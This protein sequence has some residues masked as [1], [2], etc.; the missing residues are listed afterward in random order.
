MSE[1]ERALEEEVARLQADLL[2]AR[3]RERELHE[4]FEAEVQVRTSELGDAKEAAE[5]ASRAKSRFLANMSHELRTPL[6]VIIGY[7]EMLMEDVADSGEAGMGEDL[8]K[9]Q[10][11]GKHLLGLIDD[12]LDLSKIEA[13]KMDLHWEEV[14]IDALVGELS[15]TALALASRNRNRFR[16]AGKG[17][18]HTWAD[19]TKLRQVLFNL[20]ANACK[21]TSD[22]EV[23]IAAARRRIDDREEL[24]FAV[25]DTGVGMDEE[26][27]AK[28]FR[29]FMQADASSTRKYGGTGLGLAISKRFVEM[30]GG[31][32]HVR[33]RTGEGS[34]FTVRLPVRLRAPSRP[35]LLIERALEEGRGRRVLFVGGN[36][37]RRERLRRALLELGCRVGAAA[38]STEALGRIRRSAPDLVVVLDLPNGSDR[39]SFVEA[40]SVIPTPSRL[41]VFVDGAVAGPVPGGVVCLAGGDDALLSAVRRWL[42]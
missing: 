27:V 15:D 34:T 21:F 20:L 26:T 40:L 23:Q 33:S 3:E 6:N 5:A 28:L 24:V 2:A 41:D 39:T 32:I 16:V 11:A 25:A 9:I 22:G 7:A 38:T 19:A 1:R 13:G 35:G 30:M 18:G 4:S 29:P 10:R 12:I 37:V 8:E 17:L 14:D 42:T 36:P 31:S